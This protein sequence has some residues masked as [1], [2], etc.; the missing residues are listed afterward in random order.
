MLFHKLL[1]YTIHSPPSDFKSFASA[2]HAAHALPKDQNPD[3]N[4]SRC[5]APS[6]QAPPVHVSSLPSRGIICKLRY[7]RQRCNKGVLPAQPSRSLK[8]N[9]FCCFSFWEPLPPS[10]GGHANAEKKPVPPIRFVSVPMNISQLRTP[11][12]YAGPMCFSRKCAPSALT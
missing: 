11:C 4:A 7:C 10:R 9:R 2:P 3:Q 8:H 1:R 12:V 6:S 5:S